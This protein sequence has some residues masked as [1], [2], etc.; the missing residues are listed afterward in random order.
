[1]ARQSVD[2]LSSGEVVAMN[3]IMHSGSSSIDVPQ[4]IL[5]IDMPL[6][7]LIGLLAAYAFI[8]AALLCAVFIFMGGLSFILSAGDE[9]KIKQAIN[10]IRYAIVGLIIAIFSLFVVVVVGRPFGLNLIEYLSY[11]QIIGNIKTIFKT[12]DSSGSG[13]EYQGGGSGRGFEIFR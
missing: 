4:T 2:Y 1:M 3:P 5:S 6:T 7:Q 13:G 8:I 11:D 10:T 12:D 9:S